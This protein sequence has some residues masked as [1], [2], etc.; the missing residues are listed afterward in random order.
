M[1]NQSSF[2][3][4]AENLQAPLGGEL[5]VYP[6]NGGYA[7]E[8]I[9]TPGMRYSMRFL[10]DKLLADPIAGDKGA[11]YVQ[12]VDH[13]RQENGQP[14]R[15]QVA[16][17]ADGIVH[18]RT[19]LGRAPKPGEWEDVQHDIVIDQQWHSPF[20]GTAGVVEAVVMPYTHGIA[21]S[22]NHKQGSNPPTVAGLRQIEAMLQDPRKQIR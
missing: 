6:G 4:T 17:N 16:F 20:G 7:E 5:R 1:R 10:A 11:A 18:G 15:T 3:A 9:K 22:A 21:D 13:A 14:V 8:V 12:L 2:P 19:E